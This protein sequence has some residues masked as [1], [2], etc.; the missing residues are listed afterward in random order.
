MCLI[1]FAIGAHPRFPLIVAANRDEAYA[2]PASDAAFWEDEPHVYGGRDLKRGGTWL[3][4]ASNGRFAAITNYRQRP[5]AGDAPRSRGDL[6]RD[7]LT[8]TAEPLEYLQGAEERRGQYRGFSLIAGSPHGLYFYSNRSNG[9]QPIPPGVHGLS[10][11]LLDEP[12]PKVQR[13]VAVLTGLL[14]SSE[15]DVTEA[16]LVLLRDRTAAPDHLLPSTG[17]AL[18]RERALSAAFIAGDT[19]GTRASTVVLVSKDGDVLFCE[20]TFGPHGTPLNSTDRRFN[21]SHTSGIKA[22]TRV[23]APSSGAGYQ[24][25]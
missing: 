11:R 5:R 24:P 13:G 7:Y 8:G 1:L 15:A 14:E 3:G 19:Y 12:W 23:A 6:T 22:P 18:E 10:N 17:I 4:L 16:L 25:P 21:L 20:R 2:R 9:I